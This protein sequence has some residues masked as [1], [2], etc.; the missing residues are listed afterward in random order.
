MDNHALLVTP[1]ETGAVGRMMQRLGRNYV[2]LFNGRHHCT[3]TLWEGRYRT[4][5]W[6]AK[7]YV[8]RCCRYIELS[9]VRARIMHDPVA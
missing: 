4:F 8:L 5:W 7:H 6:T 9:R 1:P 2:V 3:G